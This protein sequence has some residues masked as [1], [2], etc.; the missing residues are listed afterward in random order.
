[1]YKRQVDLVSDRE[2]K[3]PATES[4]LQVVNAMRQRGVL[5]S[6]TGPAAN[7]LKVR[8]PLVFQEEHADVF[9]TTL[10]DVLKVIDTRTW[11]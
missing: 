8:P 3:A 2:S 4:A 6:A 10:S 7:V 11:E 5:I 1:M 9:L